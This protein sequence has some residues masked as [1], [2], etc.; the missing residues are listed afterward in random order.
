MVD[1]GHGQRSQGE[2]AGHRPSTNSVCPGDPP[3]PDRNNGPQPIPLLERQEQMSALN[4]LL[5]RGLSGS[6]QLATIQGPAGIGKT[7]L[8]EET[9]RLARGL[10][11]EVLS[12]RGGELEQGH[13]LGLVL[14]LLEHRISKS[15]EEELAILFRGQAGFLRGMLTGAGSESTTAVNDEFA[16]MHSLYWLMVN[17]ADR[18]PLVLLVDD[19]QWAD[20]QSLRFFLYLAQRLEDLPI[21]LVTA[22]RSGD[23]AADN[24]LFS[25]LML[26]ADLSLRLQELSVGGVRQFL[27]ASLPPESK[28]EGLWMKRGPTRAAILFFCAK[29]LPRWCTRR[30][31][32]LQSF[33]PMLLLTRWRAASCCGFRLWVRTL[34]RL[35]VPSQY[36]ALPRH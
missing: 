10:D 29:W 3:P 22:V 7:R 17:L 14:R 33:R 34:P 13:P 26:Q 8:L 36:W 19:L 31:N 20:E 18:R 1:A 11:A 24:D 15:S 23:P 35:P 28:P 16:L 27:K 6:G 2:D 5:H 12:G 4:S 25:R 32:K 21:V 9:Q 30:A